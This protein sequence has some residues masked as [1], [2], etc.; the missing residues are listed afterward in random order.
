[1]STCD[2]SDAAKQALA[3]ALA[4]PAEVTTD[5]GTVK[6]QAL[7]D[8]LEL[9]RASAAGCAATKP[10]LGMQLRRIAPPGA[11]AFPPRYW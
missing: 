2:D 1:M 6:Q 3:D 4:G 11:V 5:A 9:A 8:L 10:A 7:A